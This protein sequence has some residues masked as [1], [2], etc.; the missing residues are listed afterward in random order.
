MAR[1]V[2]VIS[3]PV[4]VAEAKDEADSVNGQVPDREPV[5][6]DD[7]SQ[8]EEAP[9]FEIG[10]PDAL[11]AK[12]VV[13]A[14]P[15]IA[16]ASV[17]KPAKPEEPPRVVI[18]PTRLPSAPA[19]SYFR[20]AFQPLPALRRP[21]LPAEQR[22]SPE[23][24]AY[25][26]PGHEVSGQYREVVHELEGQL[27]GEKC[28]AM[29]FA[30]VRQ[31]VGVSTVVLNLAIT[32]AR[33][34]RGRVLVVDGNLARPGVADRL[35]LAPAPGLREVLYRTAPPIWAVQ[36][37][38]L[39]NLQVLPAGQKPERLSLDNWPALLDHLRSQ[40]DRILIDA[41][42]WNANQS[43]LLTTC[44]AAY[45]VLSPTDLESPR[46]NEVLGGIPRQGGR[47]RGY[48]LVQR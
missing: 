42:E 43:P 48:F 27:T 18:E 11:P 29:S 26:Q 28:P 13:P 44:S 33:Q 41:G 35:G 4:G 34:N 32:W 37:T 16:L 38:A 17:P 46:A 5:A 8:E 1:L 9:F 12:A 30:S 31:G 47:L 6:N 10:G 45:L 25:H 40:F 21:E 14:K 20:I 7:E 39:P 2:N 23:L 3:E 22:V 24:V 19:Q 15:V 36:E